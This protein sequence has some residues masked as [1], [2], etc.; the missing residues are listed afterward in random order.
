MNSQVRVQQCPWCLSCWLKHLRGHEIFGAGGSRAEHLYVLLGASCPQAQHSLPL[1]GSSRGSTGAVGFLWFL[2]HVV[3]ESGCG[4]S[5]DPGSLLLLGFPG[6]S[7]LCHVGNS[8]PFLWSPLF[9]TVS[10][11]F[12]QI[13]NLFSCHT[14]AHGDASH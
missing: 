6:I 4:H 2:V 8:S 10:A 14:A 12:C 11:E 3:A 5:A 9:P 7:V 1:A 13:N